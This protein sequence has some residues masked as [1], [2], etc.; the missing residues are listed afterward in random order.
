[1]LIDRSITYA[2]DFLI[3]AGGLM[4]VYHEYLGNYNRQRVLA[5]AEGIYTTC[6]NTL[7]F[8]EQ[9]KISPQEAAIRLAEQRIEK[10]GRLRMNR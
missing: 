8:A 1:M 7:T 4:N 6:L 5:Q 2:P 3:N 10:I 9:E